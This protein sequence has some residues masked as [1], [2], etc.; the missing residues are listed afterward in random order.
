MKR[1]T[2]IQAIDPGD[3]NL[4]NYELDDD[5]YGGVKTS[6]VDKDIF[7]LNDWRS[8]GV[9]KSIGELDA[10]LI[11]IDN[12]YKNPDKV[13]EFALSCPFSKSEFKNNASPGVRCVLP[14]EWDINEVGKTFFR[15]WF[16]EKL[17]INY[18]F[19]KLTPACFTMIDT[20][21]P[22]KP[23]Q[24]YP[25]IDINFFNGEDLGDAGTAHVALIIYLNKPDECKG[26][27]GIY[28]SVQSDCTIIKNKEHFMEY[29]DKQMALEKR[30]KRKTN[31][32][33]G[34]RNWKLI[35]KIDMKYN[36]AIFYP[37][38]LFHHPIWDKKM[39]NN[40]NYRFTQVGFI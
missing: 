11:V 5:L 28:K 20:A 14:I 25:H 16:E 15:Y 40:P 3:G 17:N 4:N 9:S 10:P 33:G 32:N 13:R 12:F 39:F 8:K 1:K 27:T 26:G 24:T 22:M 37:T 30:S 7:E 29:H 36:R 19:K 18:P 35:E 21:E 23:L 2:K 6:F 38:N 31:V 34:D